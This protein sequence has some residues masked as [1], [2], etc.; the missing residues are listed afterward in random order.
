[1]AVSQNFAHWDA[2]VIRGTVPLRPGDPWKEHNFGKKYELKKIY[3][4]SLL[5]VTELTEHRWDSVPLLNNVVLNCLSSILCSGRC[6]SD[7]ME[8]RGGLQQYWYVQTAKDPFKRE[9]ARTSLILKQANKNKYFLFPKIGS[10]FQYSS[11]YIN[12]VY[13]KMLELYFIF[14]LLLRRCFVLFLT[15]EIVFWPRGKLHSLIQSVCQS[16]FN[17]WE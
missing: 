2:A 11:V 4:K 7:W 12:N 16:R 1:M 14:K 6:T 13:C 17:W 9:H 5:D 10:V 3:S 8:T 15:N